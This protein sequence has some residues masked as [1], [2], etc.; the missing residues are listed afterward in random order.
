METSIK[1]IS[2]E[3]FLKNCYQKGLLTYTMSI[4]MIFPQEWDGKRFEGGVK[5]GRLQIPVSK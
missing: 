1:I 4:S 3:L 5:E 2:Q